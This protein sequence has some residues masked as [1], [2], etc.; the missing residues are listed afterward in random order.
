MRM[1]EDLKTKLGHMQGQFLKMYF[2]TIYFIA[3]F[4]SVK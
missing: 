2:Q 3:C 1:K 4:K